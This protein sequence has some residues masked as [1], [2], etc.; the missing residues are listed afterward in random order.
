[1]ADL[2]KLALKRDRGYLTRLLVSLVIGG[3]AAI[4]V[5]AGLT[6]KK[7]TGCVAD[8]LLGATGSEEADT[9]P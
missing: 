4:F 7:T 5:F 1:M 9:G 2:E 3:G 8:S 6:G